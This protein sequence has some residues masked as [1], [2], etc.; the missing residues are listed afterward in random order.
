MSNVQN[1]Q[2]AANR[3]AALTR[4]LLAFARRQVSQPKVM[5]PTEQ[6]IRSTKM[7]RPLLGA[8]IEPVLLVDHDV[9]NIR[10]DPTQLEQVVMN[11]AIN[12][13][14]AMPNGGKL[15][16][17]VGNV[18]VGSPPGSS[19]GGS[20]FNPMESVTDSATAGSAPSENAT[21][22]PG[23]YVLLS[24]T[25]SG[26]GMSNDVMRQLFEPFFTTKPSGK[27]TGL[28][29]ATSYGI[30]KQVGGDILVSSE[31]DVG[32]TFNVY[33]PRI[34]A[35]PDEKDPDGVHSAQDGSETILLVEDEPLVRELSAKA[36][37]RHGYTVYEADTGVQALQVL[38]THSAVIQ[39]IVTDA[40]M[41]LM[42]GKDLIER[43]YATLPNIR[44]ILASGYSDSGIT[45]QNVP[46]TAVS[47]I[48]KPFSSSLLLKTVRDVLAEVG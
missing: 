40:V 26:T 11:L 37:R 43:V 33:L 8:D 41:P 39:L 31:P 4:Q 45:F 44:F 12:A 27:G 6:L 29:L 5:A 30:V 7:L 17:R 1:I 36:L 2:G 48:Q 32:T 15:V 21:L 46:P 13:R 38:E 28:G 16:I 22:I 9:G 19:I 47:F 10:I 25:D 14:D 35:K 34:D 23:E 20:A 18:T 3:A 42:G 24:V